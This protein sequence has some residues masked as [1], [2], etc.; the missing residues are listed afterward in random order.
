MS[1]SAVAGQPGNDERDWPALVAQAEQHTQ[2]LDELARGVG[3]DYDPSRDLVVRLGEVSEFL[4]EVSVLVDEVRL[5]IGQ[6]TGRGS[7][8]TG[9]LDTF[10]GSIGPTRDAIDDFKVTLDHELLQRTAEEER[11]HYRPNKR[12]REDQQEL[13]ALARTAE[14]RLTELRGHLDRLLKRLAGR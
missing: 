11:H 9:P 1:D 12:F 6:G 10:S 5:R 7:E 8:L 13:R 2:R 4:R 14:D 3:P